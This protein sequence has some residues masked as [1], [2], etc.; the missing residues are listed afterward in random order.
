MASKEHRNALPP[1]YKL[2]WYQ[3]DRVL[4]QGAFGIT[5]LAHDINLQRHVAI[6]EYLPTELAV[7][8]GDQCVYAVSSEHA[9]QYESGLA[10]FISEARTLARFEH[11]NIVRVLNVFEANGTAY[12]VM[13]Y[14]EGESLKQRIA[15]RGT[16]EEQEL[17]HIVLPVMDGLEKIHAAGFIHRDIKP[18]N[19]FIRR[20]GSPVLLDF[21]SARQALHART[22]TL[23][24]FVSPGYAPIEQYA[25]KSDKQGPWTDIYGLGATMYK[26]VTG[27]APPP[28]VDRSD[29]IVQ[30][31]HDT[32]TSTAEVVGQSYSKAL[33]GAIDH[34]MAF[35]THE[36]PRSVREWREE[37][38]PGIEAAAPKPETDPATQ[39]V[40]QTEAATRGVTPTAPTVIAQAP[41][42]SK[43]RLVAGGLL[44]AAGMASLILILRPAPQPPTE[45]PSA[46]D[47]IAQTATPP[48]AHSP[49][50]QPAA[51]PAAA[52]G[53]QHA[54]N[55][56]AALHKPLPLNPTQ[57]EIAAQLDK[58]RQNFAA[59]R[60]STPAGNNALENYRAVLALDPDNKQAK[61]GIRDIVDKYVALAQAAMNQGDLDRAQ[62]LIGRAQAIAPGSTRVKQVQDK[63]LAKRRSPPDQ[64]SA[65]NKLDNI[66][67]SIADFFKQHSAKPSQPQPEPSR[68]DQF[69]QRLGN[70]TTR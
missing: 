27:R 8:D 50:L 28:A 57:A 43:A 6:K 1:E 67:N 3:I 60:L 56:G 40:P 19:I 7:R 46:S 41:R 23:T 14:E 69:R 59:L 61:Q 48:S 34:A 58:A 9:E 31:E 53:P 44:A 20:N 42:R 39:F 11:P 26:A 17:L 49:A 66:G 13:S 4:G 64:P 38:E 24:N 36:R 68:A 65:E 18:A 70:D 10:R 15:R 62:N 12:M 32:Y 35:K 5:Y 52:P 29:S 47:G 2:H 54:T 37:F 22:T 45:K 51:G 16:L 30:E 55:A 25:S 33:L 21:G 63:L